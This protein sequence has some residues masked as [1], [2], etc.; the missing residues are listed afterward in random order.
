MS[1]ESGFTT[2]KLEQNLRTLCINLNLGA[3]IN[4]FVLEV[5]N[6]TV[7]VYTIDFHI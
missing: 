7:V 1:D 4:D 3:K 5:L 2:K 6:Y